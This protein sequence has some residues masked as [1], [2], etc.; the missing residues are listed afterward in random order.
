MGEVHVEK[1]GMVHVIEVDEDGK[2]IHAKNKEEFVKE[3]K[4]VW[5]EWQFYVFLFSY[6]LFHLFSRALIFHTSS[7]MGILHFVLAEETYRNIWLES[8]EIT[9][10]K[11]GKTILWLFVGNVI[12]LIIAVIFALLVGY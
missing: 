12:L 11:V 4:T 6:M 7:V 5:V 9:L 2:P 8:K 3:D 1:D 10:R